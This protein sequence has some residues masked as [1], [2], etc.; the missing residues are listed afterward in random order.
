M[1][2]FKNGIRILLNAALNLTPIPKL[3][4]NAKLVGW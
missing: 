3:W 1:S 2:F 4:A